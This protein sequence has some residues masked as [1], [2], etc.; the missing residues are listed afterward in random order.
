MPTII[1][2]VSAIRDGELVDL[3]IT[4]N[5]EQLTTTLQL[6]EV[7]TAEKFAAWLLSQTL[8]PVQIE[9]DL[10]RR[11][12][13]D[14]HP[15][16]VTDPDTGE[17]YI[18]RVVDSVTGEPLPDAAA[19]AEYDSLPIA[20]MTADEAAAWIDTNVTDLASIKAGMA[21]LARAVVLLRGM[22]P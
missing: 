10:Q 18:V 6:T 11:F 22:M 16:T 19:G 2:D 5:G 3:V 7:N 8:E 9:P 17:E 14:F 13:I 21:Q 20:G 12:T 15:E 1:V 4:R